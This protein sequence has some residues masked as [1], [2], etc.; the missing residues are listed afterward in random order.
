MT[1]EFDKYVGIPFANKGRG[2]DAYD[3]WGLVWHVLHEEF[4]LDV[5]SY[6]DEYADS[7]DETSAAAIAKHRHEWLHIPHANSRLGDVV[8]MM[9]GGKLWH[10]GLL[11]PG[12]WVLHTNEGTG[13]V[14]EEVEWLWPRITGFYRW[15]KQP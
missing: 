4:G 11:L 8:E 2:P 1:S 14:A 10:V 13:S 9:R 5:P 7:N 6:A 12:G 15:V 3:C